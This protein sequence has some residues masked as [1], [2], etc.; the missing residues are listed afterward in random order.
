MKDRLPYRQTSARQSMTL[1]AA[2]CP[3]CDRKGRARMIPP[4]VLLVVPVVM[5][6]CSVRVCAEDAAPG[7]TGTVREAM[8]ANR[9]ALV[10][11]NLELT[12]AEAKA[13]WPVYDRYQ[14]DLLVARDTLF[15]VVEEDTLQAVKLTDQKA[16]ELV[17]RYLAAEGARAQIRSSYLKEI[18]QVLPGLK[19]AQ[20][21]QI[22]NKLDAL[23][24]YGMA[25][26]VPL[27]M[28]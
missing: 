14:K 24:N 4:R 27:T 20:F 18:S 28:P 25:V 26:R 9:R 12:E 15:Q 3:G 10:A 21:Y 2:G 6:L 13:F 11:A 7:D 1:V 23:I 19:V 16:L 5:L 17:Q 22:E 8:R